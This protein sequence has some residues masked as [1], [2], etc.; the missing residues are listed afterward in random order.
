VLAEGVGVGLSGAAF[1]DGAE[2][3]EA[4]VAVA[5][6]RPGL[7]LQGCGEDPL[8]QTSQP[9][10]WVGSPAERG[11]VQAGGVGEQLVDGDGVGD[12]GWEPSQVGPDGVGE[13]Q[14][15]L[16]GELAMATAVNILPSEAMG[17][18][19]WALLARPRCRSAR[20]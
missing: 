6:P 12:L 13:R 7:E 15:V 10:G 14:L 20:P 9:V 18:L 3:D 4:V 11:V 8:Q 17:N 19:V 16:L 5:E 2:D 1:Q